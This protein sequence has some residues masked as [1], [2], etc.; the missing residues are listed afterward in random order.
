VEALA[1]SHALGNVL[2]QRLS[3]HMLQIVQDLLRIG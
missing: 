3:I 2:E 1:F